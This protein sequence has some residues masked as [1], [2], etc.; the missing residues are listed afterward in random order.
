MI[1]RIPKVVVVARVGMDERGWE[2]PECG[3]EEKAHDS[4]GVD[5]L[6][7]EGKAMVSFGL[8]GG[9]DGGV[10]DRVDDLTDQLFDVKKERC[11]ASR[12]G[13]FNSGRAG[14]EGV[15]RACGVRLGGDGGI[16]GWAG[17]GHGSSR[18]FDERI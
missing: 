15:G 2:N 11:D 6:G 7:S 5:G 9:C 18:V 10:W 17:W 14:E 13:A 16:G 4:G 3:Y 12:C 8:G 1:I